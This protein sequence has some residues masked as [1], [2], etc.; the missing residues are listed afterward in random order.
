MYK[1]RFSKL[2][3]HDEMVLTEY[4][5]Y[6]TKSQKELLDIREGCR[7]NCLW[8]IADDVK[9]YFIEDGITIIDLYAGYIA[10]VLPD[11][12]FL[13]MK[14]WLGKD[15]EIF[16]IEYFIP[17]FIP[18]KWAGYKECQYGQYKEVKLCIK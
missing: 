13:Y 4:E 9:K 15:G 14:R 2:K 1:F 6:L 18:Y 3:P 16:N 11:H 10:K 5:I 12:Q 8:D 17:G 7:K